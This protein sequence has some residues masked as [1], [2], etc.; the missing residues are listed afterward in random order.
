MPAATPDDDARLLARLAAGDERALAVVFDTYG[1]VVYSLAF[2]ITQ[3]QAAAERVVTDAF[4]TLWRDARSLDIAGR[5]L[6]SWLSA[7]VRTGAL[8]ARGS[9][10]PVLDP[11]PASRVAAAID[12]LNALQR[13]VIE[14]AYFG[15]LTRGDI[16]RRLGRPEVEIAVTLRAA[17]EALRDMLSPEPVAA[18]PTPRLAGG[19]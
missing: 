3:H 9:S 7:L 8:G 13:Q 14:L 5:T 17:M 16:A 18:Q 4:A 11:A 2:A 10:T 19:V 6:F 15:G 1:S 12:R